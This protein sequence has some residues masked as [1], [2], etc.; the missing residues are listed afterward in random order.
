MSWHHW[1]YRYSIKTKILALVL[2]VSIISIILMAAFTS[3]YYTV[4]AKKDFYLLAQDSTARIN[5]QLNRYFNQ[6]AQS[7]YASIA[8]PLPTNPLLG[9]NPDSVGPS[10]D[11]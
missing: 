3:Y 6:V 9:V 2:S 8:G 1:L 4:S 5:Y 11:R 10:G 7:T